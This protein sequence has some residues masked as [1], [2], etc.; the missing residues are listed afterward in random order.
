MSAKPK[1]EEAI[2]DYLAAWK[3]DR[4]EEPPF[5]VRYERGWIRWNYG[6]SGALDPRARVSELVE[7]TKRIRAR[8]S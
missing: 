2:A 1:P 3:G 7:M 6:G 4:A 8:T 5:T